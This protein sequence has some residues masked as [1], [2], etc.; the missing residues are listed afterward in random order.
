[1]KKMKKPLIEDNS[2]KLFEMLNFIFSL[3]ASFSTMNIYVYFPGLSAFDWLTTKE[4]V[5]DI[6]K[7][8][9]WIGNLQP[10]IKYQVAKLKVL[11]KS[12]KAGKSSAWKVFKMTDA[13][14][15]ISIR[16]PFCVEDLDDFHTLWVFKWKF[17]L[18]LSF[19]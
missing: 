11:E 7:M 4:K 2:E 12:S 8:P 6:G 17:S 18:E 14:T 16:F 13:R 1:M 19:D 15:N 3:K 5:T 9:E 10:E